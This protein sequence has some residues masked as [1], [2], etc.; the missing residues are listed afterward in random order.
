MD[1]YVVQY[2]PLI[3][4][5]LWWQPL[6]GATRT[7]TTANLLVSAQ[8][9]VIATLYAA[10]A[11]Q[12]AAEKVADTKLRAQRQEIDTLRDRVRSGEVRLR[13]ELVKQQE[14]FLAELTARDR[15]YAQEI[16]VF[17]NA[18]ENIAS[19]PEGVAAL[20]RFNAGDEVGAL[21]VLDDLSAAQD[22][23][24]RKGYEIRSAVRRR[25]NAMLAL[26]ARN[27]G[28]VT[29]AQVITRFE[30]VTRLDPGVH[31]DWVELGRLYMQAGRLPNALR[32]A[33]VAA[34]TAQDDRAQAVARHHL[35]NVQVAQGNLPAAL[36]SY[37]ASLAIRQHLAKIDP[38]NAGWQRDL[39][40][41]HD[42]MGDVQVTQGNFPAALA[43]YQASLAIRERLT[44]A[45]SGNTDWQGSLSVSHEKMGDVQ[46]TQGNFPA[47][48]ASYQASHHI[49]E[50][51]ADAD[52]G[53][54]YWQRGLSVSQEK[55]G[56]V[57]AAQGNLPAALAS[58]QAS[59]HIRERLADADPGNMYWQRALSV[60]LGM[61]GD[62]QIAQGNLPAAL[63]SFQACHTIFERLAKVD[64]GNSG[65]QRDLSISHDRMGDVQVTQGNLLA[66]LASYQ[67]SL[68]I[69]ERLTK[70]DPSNADWQRD[71]SVSH[72]KMGD[73]Q[74][75]QG[76]L[77]AALA[78]YQASLAIR[79]RLA[80][81]DPGNAGWQRDLIVDYVKLNEVSSDKRYITK[82]LEVALAMQSRGILAP[83]DAWIIEELK[84]RASP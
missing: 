63:G 66:A 41:S 17:R 72:E 65:W 32:T 23:A 7:P 36:G 78:S 76:N 58:Y 21:A 52:P 55:M 74:V 5:L 13:S 15:A 49:R 12:A 79:E 84:R 2:L 77:P 45:D 47:A 11:S 25:D 27:K 3:L 83:R 67:A 57:Q 53:N 18:L 30:E 46:V 51:L 44:K 6:S 38:G 40:I 73:V 43:S 69:R 28:K 35:G 39:S 4:T 54:T 59:H 60:S 16:G 50:R 8:A 64:P 24:E 42:S 20:T 61:I 82:A 9:E 80:Q 29:T 37:Q 56:N 34:D 31:W 26:E 22:A 70:A 71:L 10:S 48:L 62:V 1:E 68:A 33:S 81:A 14:K 75:T 19:T